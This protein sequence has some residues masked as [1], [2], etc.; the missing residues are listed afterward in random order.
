MPGESPQTVQRPKGHTLH[1]LPR[2]A[3]VAAI[4]AGIVVVALGLWAVLFR[5]TWEQDNRDTILNMCNEAT[6]L[7]KTGE[8]TRFDAKRASILALVDTRRVENQELKAALQRV[9]DAGNILVAST[10]REAER[11]GQAEAARRQ[12]EQEKQRLETEVRLAAEEKRRQKEEA[13]RLALEEKKRQEDAEAQRRAEEGKQR[14][15]EEAR[16]NAEKVREGLVSKAN[17]RAEEE[18]RN[19]EAQRQAEEQ[20]RREAE[21]AQQ[22][23]EEQRR[24]EAIAALTKELGRITASLEQAKAEGR[25]VV[26][27]RNQLQFK[28]NSERQQVQQQYQAMVEDIE[29]NYQ[30]E[31]RLIFPPHYP[32][33]S[34]TPAE[35]VEYQRQL[36]EYHRLLAEVARRRSERL[37]AAQAW[38]TNQYREIDQRYQ[39]QVMAIDMKIAQL[40][41]VV[42]SLM[43][44]QADLQNKLNKM[45]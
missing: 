11:V 18:Q 1:G 38:Q 5:D 34:A 14:L 17:R 9:E 2:Y 26:Q 41:E 39:P 15:A 35:R 4:S 21:A 27:E 45:R 30:F 23:A 19:A 22:A 42:K 13:E 24:Q 43:Q 20:Q 44:S 25:A 40:E 3:L 10:K 36:G 37:L 7:A 12:A 29:K 31:Q 16:Q 33:L 28:Y 8:L 32:P 6:A